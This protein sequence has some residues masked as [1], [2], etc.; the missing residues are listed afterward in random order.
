MKIES[1]ELIV[2]YDEVN[3]VRSGVRIIMDVTVKDPYPITIRGENVILLF[4][5]FL[6]DF[7]GIHYAYNLSVRNIYICEYIYI[8]MC[9]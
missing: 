1:S 3:T 9:P 8:L 4:R 6:L 7:E 5:I 2:E